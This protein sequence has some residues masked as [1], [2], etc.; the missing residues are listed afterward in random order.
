MPTLGIRS[1][2]GTLIP[3]PI[4]AAGAAAQTR[5]YP[6][7]VRCGRKTSSFG[8]TAPPKRGILMVLYWT[9]NQKKHWDLPCSDGN[10][11]FWRNFFANMPLT[12]KPPFK[13]TAR[14]G[15]GVRDGNGNGR[16]LYVDA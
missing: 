6:A 11:A 5:Q 15:A 2:R 7:P 14:S 16:Y 4:A 8:Q 1:P 12:L 13:Q 3:A 9:I 10:M